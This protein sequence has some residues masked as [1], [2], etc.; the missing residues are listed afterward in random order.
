MHLIDTDI[1]THLHAGRPRVVRAMEQLDDP[2]A[3]ITIVTQIE[4]LRGRFDF[5]LKASTSDELLRAQA[6]LRRTQELLSQIII[7]PFDEAAASHFDRLRKNKKM[8][9]IGR[10]DLIIA[11]IA[12]ANHATLVTRNLRHFKQVPGLKIVNWLP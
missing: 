10:A 6:L 2:D 9:K 12:L 4:L 3:C 5:L 7:I 8:R 1:L 11:S